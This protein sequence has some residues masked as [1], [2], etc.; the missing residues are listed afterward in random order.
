MRGLNYFTIEV[1]LAEDTQAIALRLNDAEYPFKWRQNYTTL[2]V[3]DPGNSSFS[4][5]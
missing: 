2:A 3:T 4:E 1:P 5:S